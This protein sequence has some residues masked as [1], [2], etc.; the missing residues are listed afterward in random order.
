[1]VVRHIAPQLCSGQ[2]VASV[3]L[4]FVS[5]V[6]F[7]PE[8]EFHAVHTRGQI[9]PDRAYAIAITRR[10]LV[11]GW[12]GSTSYRSRGTFPSG[13]QGASRICC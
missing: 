4:L 1:M 12:I 2:H 10:V 6:Y 11:Q 9:G 3:A 8:V 5:A 13:C 7:G